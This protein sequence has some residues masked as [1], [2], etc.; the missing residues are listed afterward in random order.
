MVLARCL[1]TLTKRGEV[2]TLCTY[3]ELED[4][5]ITRVQVEAVTG[6]IRLQAYGVT[7]FDKFITFA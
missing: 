7:I 1:R 2:L 4:H 5:R 6:P 3:L